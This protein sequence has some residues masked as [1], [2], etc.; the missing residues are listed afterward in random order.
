ML[1]QLVA[2]PLLFVRSFFNATGGVESPL[3]H[4]RAGGARGGVRYALGDRSSS[5]TKG[6]LFLATQSGSGAQGSE[7]T[8]S[9]C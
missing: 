7:R 6:A 3:G 2:Q 5:P 9:S 4:P 1:W 8:D